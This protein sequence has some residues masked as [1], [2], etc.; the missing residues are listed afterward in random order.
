MK[1]VNTNVSRVSVAVIF[2]V[3]TAFSVM[4]CSVEK[5]FTTTKTQTYT[6]AEQASASTDVKAYEFETYTGEKILINKNNIVSQEPCDEPLEWDGIPK[7]AQQLAPGRDVNIFAD[8]DHYYIAD[9]TNKLV[10]T[11]VREVGDIIEKTDYVVF[12]NNVFTFEYDSRYFILTENENNVTVSFSNEETQ[13]AGSNTITIKEIKNADASEVIKEYA[14]QYG[15][16]T[17][18]INKSKFG[19]DSIASYSFNVFPSGET[20]S[21]NQTRAMVCAVVKGENAIVIEVN[22]HVEPDEGMDM[23]INYKIAEV[24]DTFAIN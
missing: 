16:D 12:D 4:G 2:A 7:D 17:A 10:T 18:D 1:R 3:A 5:S 23:F 9:A 14:K 8:S 21:G 15:V 19:K 13:T 20:E 22:S 6:N 24:L 11:A